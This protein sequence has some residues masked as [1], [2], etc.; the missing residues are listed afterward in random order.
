VIPVTIAAHDVGPVGG[1]ERHLTE[2]I[3]GLHRAGHDVTVV[4]RT[5]ELPDD[6]SVNWVRVPGPSRPFVVAFPWFAVAGSLLTALRRRG[7]L[8]VT[9][10]IVVNRSDVGTVHLCH[11]GIADAAV[12]RVSRPDWAHLL[13]ARMA[14]RLSRLAERLVYRPSRTRHLV[15]VSR[16]V[17]EEVK[18]HF[19]AMRGR[20][21]V[22]PNGVDHQRFRRNLGVRAEMRVRLGIPESAQVALFVGSEWEGK[23][24]ALAIEAV[25]RVPG[26][27]LVVVGE[28]D[29]ARYREAARQLGA[30]HAVHFV[31]RVRDVAPYCSAADV[32]V[33]PSVYETFSLAAYEA[34]AAGLPL[35]VTRVSGVEDLLR[36][37]DNGSFVER[38]VAD[39]AGRLGEL[40]ADPRR[41]A[42][43][44][45]RS[46]ELV[47]GFTWGAMVAA[48]RDLYARLA[49]GDSRSVA[50]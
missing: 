40:Q 27:H 37:G 9:G 14:A 35:L 19:P 1:M 5:C 45:E 7:L 39:I 2:L 34:A 33:L 25:A 16:G 41:R 47:E 15:G 4:S 31:G 30:E 38:S 17:A 43:M 22:I 13:N 3:G 50:A 28:G 46:A 29:A 44:G 21:S 36:H 11:V 26:C 49:A 48:Y 23:G 42:A 32:F 18:R 8:H 20:V 24:L 6:V 12:A 10:A